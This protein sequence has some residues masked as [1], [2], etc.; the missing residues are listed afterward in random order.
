M[1]LVWGFS[2]LSGSALNQGAAVMI[3]KP[4][5][6]MALRYLSTTPDRIKTIEDENT[7]A[8][9]VLYCDLQKRGLVTID[10]EDGML[11][12]ISPAGLAA[13]ADRGGER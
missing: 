13:V 9:A 3:L 8:A 5:E 10:N 6:S 1:G 4:H 7:F 11:V 12:T 2:T